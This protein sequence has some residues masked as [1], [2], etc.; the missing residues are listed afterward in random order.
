MPAIKARNAFVKLVIYTRQT[1]TMCHVITASVCLCHAYWYLYYGYLYAY[2]SSVLRLWGISSI[3]VL[4]MLTQ[5]VYAIYNGI[6]Q[7]A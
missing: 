2:V 3:A 6:F 4:Y 1:V 5:R 7:G